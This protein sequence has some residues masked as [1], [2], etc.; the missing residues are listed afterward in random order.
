MEFLHS[1]LPIVIYFLIIAI[2]VVG[3]I[4]GIKLVSTLNRVDKV[5][6]DTQRK[7]LVLQPSLNLKGKNPYIQCFYCHKWAK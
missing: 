7:M 3:I 5:V 4:L 2:L 6:E 1:F